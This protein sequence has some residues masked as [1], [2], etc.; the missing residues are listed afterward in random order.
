MFDKI[1]VPE[2][3]RIRK[4]VGHRALSLMTD[5][6]IRLPFSLGDQKRLVGYHRGYQRDN[7]QPMSCHAYVVRSPFSN[8]RARKK[9][10]WDLDGRCASRISSKFRRPAPGMQMERAGQ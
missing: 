7:Q 5:A 2:L 1:R 8:S 9:G 3:P 4:E 6:D 10:P